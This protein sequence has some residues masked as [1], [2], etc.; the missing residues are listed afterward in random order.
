MK[1]VL[2]SPVKAPHPFSSI[3]SGDRLLIFTFVNIFVLISRPNSFAINNMFR[4]SNL[5]KNKGF[6]KLWAF[7]LGRANLNTGRCQNANKY[8]N[9]F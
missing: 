8:Y 7:Q 3:L 4:P 9:Y 5:F 6:S 2:N 1:L